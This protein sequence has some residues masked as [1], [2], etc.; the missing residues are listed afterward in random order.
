[1]D[2]IVFSGQ[3]NMQG[4]TESLPQDNSPVDGAFEYRFADDALVPLQNPV[5]E[6]LDVNG[7]TFNPDFS[8]IPGALEKS[9]LLAAW[10]NHTNMVPTFCKS[11]VSV[12]GRKVA[13]VHA[14]KGSTTIDYWLK[15]EPGY[16]MLVRKTKAAIRA[17]KPEHIFFVWLQGESDALAGTSKECYKEKI[18]MLNNDLKADIGI[19]KF[20]VVLVGKFAGDIR[21][22]YISDAQREV[23]RENE[24]FLLLTTC[25]E[26]M[27]QNAEYMNPFEYGHF[28][29][30]GQELIGEEAGRALGI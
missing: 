16:E 7:K 30:R 18:V 23:C 3:S 21:D 4:Q 6:N 26:E 11:Y 20:G 1:M 17:V 12:T 15:G 8:D 22:K 10:E 13:A 14:A 28:S 19:E 24:D 27:T 25:T 2:L 5:G 9:S 29:T